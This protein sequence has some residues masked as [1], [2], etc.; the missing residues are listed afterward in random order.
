MAIGFADPR[1]ACHLPGF[2]ACEQDGAEQA[3]GP[4]MGGSTGTMFGWTSTSGR[5]V[6]GT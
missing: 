4:L 3:T 2:R 6:P 5:V 1:A